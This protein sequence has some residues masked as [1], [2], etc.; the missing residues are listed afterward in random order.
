MWI[1]KNTTRLEH[2]HDFVVSMHHAISDDLLEVAKGLKA[3]GV[4]PL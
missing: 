3:V 2:N 1:L 4:T